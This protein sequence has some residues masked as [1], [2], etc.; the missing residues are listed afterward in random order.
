MLLLLI[1]FVSPLQVESLQKQVRHS[2]LGVF[3]ALF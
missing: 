3:T 2:G 1:L